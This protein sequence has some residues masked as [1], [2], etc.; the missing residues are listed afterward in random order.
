MFVEVKTL[1]PAVRDALKAVR[2]GGKDIKVIVT[3]HMSPSVAGGSGQRGFVTIINLTTG[4]SESMRG[5]WGG[6]NMFNPNNTVDLDTGQY[7][8][9]TD[10]VV[11]KGTTGYP[12]TFAVLYTTAT[13]NLLPAGEGDSSDEVLSKEE[14]NALYCHHAIKG[15][16]YRRDELIRKG[17]SPSTVDS[18]VDRGYLKRNRAGAVSITTKGKNAST[19]RH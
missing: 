10:G 17:V 9:P 11:I 16:Q 6:A 2:Y 7:V 4:K 19:I 5:S 3:D 13:G 1:V 8:I 18:L 15:G 14:L 12:R